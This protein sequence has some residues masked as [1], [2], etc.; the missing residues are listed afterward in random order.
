MSY[1]LSATPTTEQHSENIMRLFVRSANGASATGA[2]VKVWAGQPPHGSPAYWNDDEPFRTIAASGMLEYI[3]MNGPMPDTRDYW[4]QVIDS[5]GAAQSDPVQFHFPQGSTLWITATLTQEGASVPVGGGGTGPTTVEVDPRLA[6]MHV[7]LQPLHVPSGQAY[8]KI[9]SVKYQDTTESDNNHNIYYTALDENGIPAPG[10]PIFMDWQGRPSDDIPASVSTDGNG[11]GNQ[12]MYHGP[13]GWRPE[14][15]PGPY[16]AWIGD[17]DYRGNSPTKI[18]GE[19]LVGCGL[20]M[21][22]HVN[23][24]VTWKKVIAGSPVV[25]SDGTTDQSAGTLDQSAI[26]AAQKFK[27]M[28]INTDGALFKFAMQ[29]NLGYPQTDEFEFTFNHT[30][31]VGQVYH[32]GIVY[33]AKDDL[34]HCK[35]VKKTVGS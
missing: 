31:Y 30:S 6:P 14:N 8:W 21:N 17:P 27:W 23:Y 15:G 34:G 32:G 24:V 7:T 18:P 19:K 33:A 16:T 4:M 11:A 3:A 25:P 26:A 2:H 1:K 9:I 12:A 5:S 28:P 35:W 13:V 22:F 29:Q 10:I 20:P